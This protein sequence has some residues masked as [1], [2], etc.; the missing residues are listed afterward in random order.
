VEKLRRYEGYYRGRK[1][2]GLGRYFEK[3]YGIDLKLFRKLFYRICRQVSD[4]KVRNFIESRIS[5]LSTGDIHYDNLLSRTDS[6]YPE[7]V[8]RIEEV[9]DQ[10]LTEMS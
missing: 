5:K 6:I 2:H 3:K 8:K 4:K 10:V 7:I 1:L 9:I